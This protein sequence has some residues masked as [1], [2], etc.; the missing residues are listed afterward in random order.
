MSCTQ[1]NSTFV[2]VSAMDY[3][4]NNS[5]PQS[6]VPTGFDQYQQYP[7][8]LTSY[9]TYFN[10]FPWIYG[11]YDPLNQYYMQSMTG[12]QI[13]AQ[14]K[15][16]DGP[17]P[18][19]RIC[20]E[21]VEEL[22][23][24]PDND[25]ELLNIPNDTVS[26]IVDSLHLSTFDKS[27]SDQDYSLPSGKGRFILDCDYAIDSLD[28]GPWTSTL[29][30]PISFHNVEEGKKDILSPPASPITNIRTVSPHVS[31]SW[32]DNTVQQYIDE[33]PIAPVPSQ[34]IQMSS[35]DEY[36]LSP[37]TLEVPKAFAA[38]QEP[39]QYMAKP[40]SSQKSKDRSRSCNICSEIFQN[41]YKLK[42]H[43]KTHKG[44]GPYLCTICGKSFV[45]ESNLNTHKRIHTGEKPYPCNRC[46][47]GFSHPSDRLAHMVTEACIRMER[48]IR[49]T[50]KGWECTDCEKDD[51]DSRDQAE[52]HA[53]QHQT[54][55][56]KICPVCKLSFYGKKSNI[57]VKHVREEHPE[58][59]DG[60][61]ST[62]IF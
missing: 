44:I 18:A 51:F 30:H 55:Q 39:P 60:L 61:I 23:R 2:F 4:W 27:L 20:V 1:S 8:P 31:M 25:A 11:H 59:I 58:Y 34:S 47:R 10:G 52:R 28:N 29:A 43:M 62:K 35:T 46:G 42:M 3:Q 24:T 9:E 19:K 49:R 54:G 26:S 48:Y 41:G 50:G 22:A 21:A 12:Y 6:A 33:Q 14:S 38:Y 13:E 7:Q 56:G 40:T 37:W 57:L 15:Q 5:V 16:L 32:L 53:R 36:Q 17:P 45:S